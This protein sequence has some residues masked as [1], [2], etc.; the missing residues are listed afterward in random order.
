MTRLGYGALRPN[1]SWVGLDE[2]IGRAVERLGTRDAVAVERHLAADLPLAYVD[3]V[4]IEQVVFNLLDNAVAYA[5]PGSTVR[6]LVDRDADGLVLRVI[7]EG[8][9]V[10]VVDREQVFDL[11]YRARHGDRRNGGT[12]L[13]LAICRG[14]VEAHGGQIAVG[15]GP[16]GHGASFEVRLPLPDAPAMPEREPVEA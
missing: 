7:D 1:R 2:V 16:G 14:F 6:V 11:F 4:L 12:G 9:G 13:G 10:A 3:P 15:D 8:P 5:P